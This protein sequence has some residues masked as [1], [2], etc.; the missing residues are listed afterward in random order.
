MTIR[1][2]MLGAACV[3]L[4][5]A[6]GI[7]PS[8]A[9]AADLEVTH[10]WTSGGE[11]AAV[12][13]L[14]NA[15]EA[16]GKNKWVDGAIA[17]SGGVARPIIISRI[18]GGDPMGATQLNHGLQAQE[19]MEAGLL[20]D[21]TDVAEAGHWRDIIQPVSLLDACTLDGKVYCAPLNIHSPQWV[22]TSPAAYEAAG[23][24]PATNWEEMKA[25]AD[26]MRA[27][28]K[29]PLAVG[30]QGWQQAYVLDMLILEYAGREGYMAAYGEGDEDTLH[31]E[32]VTKAFEELAIAREMSKGTNV[33]DWNLAT[34]KII[35]NDAGAQI[36]G[37]WAQS[38]F[39]LAGKKPGTD[40]DC[41]IGLGHESVISTGGDAIYFPVNKDPEVTAA[42]KELARVIVAPETQVAFNLRKGSL[43]IR[44]DI[45]M[46]KAG[47]CMQ[48]GLATL[49]AGNT[50]PSGDALITPDAVGQIQD[51]MAEFFGGDMAPADAQARFADIIAYDK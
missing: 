35:N 37:D 12:R 27:A 14:A 48:K 22:W 19:L 17:G 11:A 30:A 46:S 47:T 29:L 6:V 9:D 36:M 16:D 1:T 10:W 50:V 43:P 42:Q 39:A 23:V 28:G 20:Q 24:K 21:I 5:L 3:A 33:Q 49:E 2:F 13:E 31:G 45:D 4:P 32:A 25:S 26:A 51:L 44:G 34:A 8:G 41:F 38:E 7:A 40:Y 18:L 15:F